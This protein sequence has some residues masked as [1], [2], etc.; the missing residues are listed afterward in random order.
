[1]KRIRIFVE[2]GG[3]NAKRGQ[4][5]L[6]KGFNGLLSAQKAAACQKK[7]EWNIACCGGRQAAYDAFILAIGRKDPDDLVVLLVDSEGAVKD[8]AAQGRVGHLRQRDNW[9]FRGVD[10]NA[11]HLMIQCMESWIVADPDEVEKFFGA[12]FHRK[13]LPKRLDLD[14]EPKADVA[15]SLELATQG[16]HK[17]YHKIKTACLLLERIRPDVVAKR[18]AS[19]KQFTQ[20]LN[21]AIALA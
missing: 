7:I 16:T 21:N 4:D 19:F 6:R 1:M 12:D 13:H 10:A 2:G 20:W 9:Q 17:K 5:A 14:N 18:C 15:R 11:V 8:T 3:P